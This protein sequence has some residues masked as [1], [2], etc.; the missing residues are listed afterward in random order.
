M[1]EQP[2]KDQPV[3]RFELL[4]GEIAVSDFFATL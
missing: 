3:G 2:A 4:R 1:A